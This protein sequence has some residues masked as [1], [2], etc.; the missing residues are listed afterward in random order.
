MLACGDGTAQRDDKAPG[1][2]SPDA[3][4]FDAHV[5][6]ALRGGDP[7]ELLALDVAEARALWVSGRGAWQVLAGAAGGGSWGAEVAY[8][9]E[10]YGVHYIVATWLP[11]GPGHATTGRA[12]RPRPAEP[13]SRPEL[14]PARGAYRCGPTEGRGRSARGRRGL[15]SPPDLQPA[16]PVRPP[17]CS[18]TRAARRCR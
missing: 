6:A 14:V 1:H 4:A 16:L 8:A 10:P 13:G 2:F 17:N 11:P 9:A 3:A 18:S 12:L 5:D 15:V 7:G